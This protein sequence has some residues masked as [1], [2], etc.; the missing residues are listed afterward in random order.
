[1]RKPMRHTAIFG[2]MLLLAGLLIGGPAFGQQPRG[3]GVPVSDLPKDLQE[4]DIKDHFVPSDF[5]EVGVLHGL[6]GSVVVI[7]RS[8]KSAYFGKPGD[9]IFE[10]DEVNTLANSRC[11][12]R[13]YSDDVVNMA[14][15]TTFAVESFED[16]RKTKKK[17]SFFSMLKGKAMFYALRLFRYRDTR[18]RVKTPT[19]IVGVR[20]TKFG[21]DVFWVEGK[22]AAGTGVQVAD[23]GRGFDALLALAGA[24]GMQ[25]GTVVACGDGHLDLTDPDTG[26]RIAEVFPNEDFNTLTQQKTF[27]PTNATL[28][29][30]QSNSEVVEEGQKPK[31]PDDLGLLIPTP[32]EISF[33]EGFLPE[34]LAALLAALFDV[35]NIQTGLATEEAGSSA[36]VPFEGT[37]D[38]PLK[39]YFAA[40]MI[41]QDSKKAKDA[42]S[43]FMLQLLD[44]LNSALAYGAK[45]SSH[46]L[47]ADESSGDDLGKASTA[48]GSSGWFSV[49]GSETY[50]A[51]KT[52]VQLGYRTLNETPTFTISTEDLEIFNKVWFVEGYPTDTSELAAMSGDYAYG[53]DVWG[54][55]YYSPVGMSSYT[56]QDM[57]GSYSCDVHFGSSYVHNFMLNA[58]GGSHTVSFEQSGTATIDSYGQFGSQISGGMGSMG[59]TFE[60]DGVSTSY[61]EINGAHFGTDAK[62]QGGTAAAVNSDGSKAFI[63]AF[64][65]EQE[66]P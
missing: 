21:V 24:Q 14:P 22:S 60:L 23:S 46:E 53:G 36:I 37:S 66:M 55:F 28:I 65:G 5:R 8:D 43:S 50:K 16:S 38:N 33:G 64:I 4:L 30:I 59:G 27:D 54:T 40:F 12:L 42:L 49:E 58:S 2:T 25:S 6:N 10:N 39:G 62:E 51:Q 45:S 32:T 15:D 11:R 63:G 52:A 1:M 34:D 3:M 17:T 19:A 44:P 56:T 13:F 9:K 7:H 47:E 26:K 41:Y 57:T 35:T 48:M 20:G 18:F 29:N 61:W 31:G